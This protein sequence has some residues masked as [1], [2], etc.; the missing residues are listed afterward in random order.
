METFQEA[1]HQMLREFRALLQHSPVPVSCTRFLQ[2]LALN[3]FA[4]EN[5]QLKGKSLYDCSQVSKPDTKKFC[6]LR[7]RHQTN[8]LIYNNLTF[9]KQNDKVLDQT[10]DSFIYYYHWRCIARRNSPGEM[11]C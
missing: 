2:L 10:V 1:A 5:T 6:R 9:T 4:I 3:M 11:R 7:R 8:K